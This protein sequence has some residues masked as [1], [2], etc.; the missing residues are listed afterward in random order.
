MKKAFALAFLMSL[1][2]ASA[3]ELWAVQEGNNS[4]APHGNWVVNVQGATL[5][6]TATTFGAGGSKET[7]N[8]EGMVNADGYDLRRVGGTAC[9]YHGKLGSDGKTIAG[10]V[11]CGGRSPPGM[12]MVKK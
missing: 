4:A 2:G 9:R 12:V 8:I 6:G 7:F 10:S 11:D 1:S 5:T 3:A